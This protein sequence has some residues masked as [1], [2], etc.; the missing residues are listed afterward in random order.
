MRPHDRMDRN[1][2]PR[3]ALRRGDPASEPERAPG[4][5]QEMRRAMLNAISEPRRS[6]RPGEGYPGGAAPWDE[7]DRPHRAW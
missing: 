3:E 5:S 7:R 4:E 2:R 6:R 1:E